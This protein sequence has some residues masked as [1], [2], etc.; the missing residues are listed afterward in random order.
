R[1]SSTVISSPLS[2]ALRAWFALS[3][4]NATVPAMPAPVAAVQAA[5][6]A[7]LPEALKR[8][9][10]LYMNLKDEEAYAACNEYL[11]AN[12]NSPQVVEVRARCL[13]N[14]GR[15]D[16]A[17]QA[18]KALPQ[19]TPSMKLLLAECLAQTKDGGRDAAQLGNEVAAADPNRV[20]ARVTRAR[21]YIAARKIEEAQQELK[22]AVSQAPKN[23]EANLLAAWMTDVSGQTEVAMQMYRPLCEKANE[24]EV[25]D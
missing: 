21:V 18:L 9:A 10:K 23:F 15:F 4:V 14:L 16:E 13:R 25:S 2:A 20:G 6:S 1:E 22:F 24:F 19:R 5:Q 17:V 8:I 7:P 12:P 3:V 11:V